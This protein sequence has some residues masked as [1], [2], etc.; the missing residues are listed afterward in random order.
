MGF[1]MRTVLVILYR[2]K[3]IR[4]HDI[5]DICSAYFPHAALVLVHRGHFRS[6]AHAVIPDQFGINGVIQILALK[7][8]PG[9]LPPYVILEIDFT[10]T[11]LFAI[12]NVV[13]YLHGEIE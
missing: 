10:S 11:H 6:D 4:L 12:E 8:C 3:I 9:N 7:E 5:H 2:Q 1:R 13:L